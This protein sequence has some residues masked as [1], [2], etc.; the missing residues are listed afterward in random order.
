MFGTTRVTPSQAATANM[1]RIFR[2]GFITTTNEELCRDT[3]LAIKR[4][5]SH[6][7]LVSICCKTCTV[8]T[9]WFITQHTFYICVIT[10]VQHRLSTLSTCS[11]AHIF[12]YYKLWIITNNEVQILSNILLLP[13]L[14]KKQAIYASKSDRIQ[15]AIC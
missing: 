12:N 10:T 1:S 14:N 6:P 9:I 8:T 4:W 11:I 3:M 13:I 7:T 15:L 2:I 5:F